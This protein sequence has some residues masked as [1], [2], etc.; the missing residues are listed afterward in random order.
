MRVR[1]LPKVL[2]LITSHDFQNHACLMLPA[3]Y[4]PRESPSSVFHLYRLRLLKGK[5][6]GYFF[7]Y[8]IADGRKN[9]KKKMKISN[10][11][12]LQILFPPELPISF[13]PSRVF[14]LTEKI[15]QE[16][17]CCYA[18]LEPDCLEAPKCPICFTNLDVNFLFLLFYLLALFC[19][20]LNPHFFL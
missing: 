2:L 4:P 16:N 15:V 13:L 14:L 3:S 11:F 7:S 19:H 17:Y 10:D 6:G 8:P 9:P 5:L 18:H 1:K 12:R 20:S